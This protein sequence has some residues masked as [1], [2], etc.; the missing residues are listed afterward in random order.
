[1]TS[2]SV[3]TPTS[4]WREGTTAGLLGA[5]GVAAWFFVVDIIAGQPLYTPAMLGEALLSGIGYTGKA[6]MLVNAALYTVFHVG[7]FMLVGTAAS[8]LVRLAERVPHVTVGLLLFFVV[9]ELGFYFVAMMLSHYDVVG[10]L[11]W[12]QIGAANIVA[13]SL[14]GGYLWRRHPAITGQFKVALDGRE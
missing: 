9:F 4:L 5:G 1:M 10:R 14:M 12:Y 13:A 11:A 6:P 8:R 7:V 3:A 2:P